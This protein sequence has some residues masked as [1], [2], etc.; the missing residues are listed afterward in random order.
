MFVDRVYEE[1]LRGGILRP[2]NTTIE[3]MRLDEEGTRHFV[4]TN[5]S[6]TI[7]KYFL[8]KAG[9]FVIRNSLYLDALHVSKFTVNPNVVSDFILTCKSLVNIFVAFIDMIVFLYFF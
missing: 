9:N 6:A 5:G 7:P 2:L 8:S 4:A 3:G 1:L